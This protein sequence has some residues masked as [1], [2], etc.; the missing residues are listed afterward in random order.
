LIERDR[1]F[2]FSL[3]EK[4]SFSRPSI[5]VLFESAA[6]TY[7][8]NLIGII[9]TG[10]NADGAAGLAMIKQYGGVTIVQSPQTSEVSFMPEA[11]IA[12]SEVDHICDLK[13]IITLLTTQLSK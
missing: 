11:A 7:N 6:V 8:K 1:T 10:A 2:S 12:A 4:V 9:L 5:D 3:E 13:D